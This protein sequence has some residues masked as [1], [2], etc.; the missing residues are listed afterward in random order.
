MY[1]YKMPT[2]ASSDRT[3][4]QLQGLHLPRGTHIYDGRLPWHTHR[5]RLSKHENSH[6]QPENTTAYVSDQA[7]E[8]DSDVEVCTAVT[9]VAA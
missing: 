3:F 9:R 4:Q 1:G 6:L 8:E 2:E 7:W 5:H